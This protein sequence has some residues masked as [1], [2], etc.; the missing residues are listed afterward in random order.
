M[1]KTSA[2]Y[3]NESIDIAP[4]FLLHRAGKIV[5]PR[6]S[7]TLPSQDSESCLAPVEYWVAFHPR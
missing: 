3:Q 1:K 5:V 7:A 4:E 6:E 2:D